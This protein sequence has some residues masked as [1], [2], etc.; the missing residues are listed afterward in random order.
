MRTPPPPCRLCLPRPKLE[1]TQV[2]PHSR[3]PNLP[4]L[5]ALPFWI[6]R[7]R[8]PLCQFLIGD[9]A[10]SAAR[11]RRLPLKHAYIFLGVGQTG[12]TVNAPI[13]TG[14]GDS[15]ESG[16]SKSK[17][18]ETL[19]KDPDMAV[20]M[21]NFIEAMRRFQ[22]C[23]EHSNK[24]MNPTQCTQR[25]RTT[26]GT[27]L[28]NEPYLFPSKR[29]EV[30]SKCADVPLKDSSETTRPEDTRERQLCPAPSIEVIP[31]YTRLVARCHHLV[32]FAG[33][34]VSQCRPECHGES[35]LNTSQVRVT[36]H[37]K[38]RYTRRYVGSVPRG[39][40]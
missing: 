12:R 14:G 13:T 7:S 27:T 3:P 2:R 40:R 18:F 32:D 16:R 31:A 22:K 28:L 8:T 11:R 36:A 10:H 35:G 5:A 23:G 6:R 15:I 26:L 38:C 21:E 37:K 20:S 1:Y 39:I 30:R 17:S 19:L 34:N 29:Q 4:L 25:G 24:V 9:L 33:V